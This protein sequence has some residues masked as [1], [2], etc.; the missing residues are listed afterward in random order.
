MAKKILIVEDDEDLRKM[1][2][3]ILQFD[4]EVSEAATGTE[5][6]EKAVFAKPNL[7]ILDLELPDMFGVVVAHAIRE[8]PKT[9][10]IPIIGW[11][12][13]IGWEYRKAALDAGMVDY[14][15][16]PVHLDTIREK[17]EE[18]LLTERSFAPNR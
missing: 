3:S 5:A 17:I 15:E 16:K 14:L 1:L 9:A 4:Y 12:A 7:I 10:C 2:V 6:I 8:E 13:Y 11:S 18:Y